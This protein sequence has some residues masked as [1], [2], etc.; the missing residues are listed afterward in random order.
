[1]C[2]CAVALLR[3]GMKPFAGM[4]LSSFAPLL[5]LIVLHH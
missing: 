4:S 3:V 2:A 1:M 5:L